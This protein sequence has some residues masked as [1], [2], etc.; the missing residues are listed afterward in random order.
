MPA[1]RAVAQKLQIHEVSRSGSVCG[2]GYLLVVHQGP[3]P[4]EIGKKELSTLSAVE[5]S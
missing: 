4:L 1:E 2:N 3:F 5:S